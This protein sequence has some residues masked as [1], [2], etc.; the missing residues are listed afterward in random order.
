MNEDTI[1]NGW[2][3][4]KLRGFSEPTVLRDGNGALIG[5]F[6][7]AGAEAGVLSHPTP[8]AGAPVVAISERLAQ[9]EAEDPIP[10][11]VWDEV[12]RLPRPS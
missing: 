11:E 3:T 9:M 1:Y 5:T 8:D 10:Q 6:V 12:A 7:P 2:F 4:R